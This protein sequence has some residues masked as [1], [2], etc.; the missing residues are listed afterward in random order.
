MII[1]IIPIVKSYNSKLL[2]VTC[3]RT[4]ET[5]SSDLGI[6]CFHP[7]SSVIEPQHLIFIC[8][9]VFPWVIRIRRCLHLSADDFSKYGIM[10]SIGCQLRQIICGR[11]MRLSIQPVRIREMRVCE[12]KLLCFLVHEIHESFF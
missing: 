12:P 9:L 2:P 6:S 8:P 7:V 10:Q 3:S 1:P 4:N 5:P 11:I